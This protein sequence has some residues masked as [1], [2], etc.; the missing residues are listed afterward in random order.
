MEK[1]QK[2]EMA[3]AIEFLT[4]S[5][6]EDSTFVMAIIALA[7]AYIL[8]AARGYDDPKRMFPVGEKLVNKA[9]QLQPSSGPA[10]ASHA[11]LLELGLNFKEAEIEFRKSIAIEPNQ[12][13][14]YNWLGNLRES[15]GD[16]KDAV[17][18]YDAGIVYN[19]EWRVIKGNKLRCLV[20][21]HRIDEAIKLAFEIFDG[22]EISAHGRLANFCIEFG[23]TKEAVHFA[24]KANNQEF[25]KRYRDGDKSASIKRALEN[26]RQ[27]DEPTPH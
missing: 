8:S 18:I 5:V 7:D 23:F 14:V 11:H 19:P 27:L 21:L 20:R 1:R 17:L 6:N 3:E 15:Y 10:I 24:E 2:A 12:S 16:F 25:L 22:D 13:N 9:L 4:Q 26:A